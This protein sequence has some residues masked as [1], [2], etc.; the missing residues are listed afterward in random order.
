M[1]GTERRCPAC[2]ERIEDTTDAWVTGAR[3]TAFG[4]EYA[5]PARAR[6]L[7]PAAGAGCR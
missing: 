5:T 3:V 4:V 7:T 6:T 1:D 2:G